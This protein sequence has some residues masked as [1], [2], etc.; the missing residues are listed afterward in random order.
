MAADEP[1]RAQRGPVFPRV[2]FGKLISPIEM[3]GSIENFRMTLEGS[4]RSV[5]GPTPY[6]PKYRSAGGAIPS[7]PGR[8][9]VY[10]YGPMHGIFHAV[11]QN[12]Q[13]EILLVHVAEELWTFEGWNKGWRVL[14]SATDSE[15]Q[16]SVR[17][18]DDVR[19]RA[20]TQFVAT[21]NGVIII[22]QAD[23][24]SRPYF[25]DGEVIL[26][27]GYSHAPSAPA[28]IGPTS[29]AGHENDRDSNTQGLS[30]RRHTMNRSRRSSAFF[31]GKFGTGRIGTISTIPDADRD[32]A[33]ERNYAIGCPYLLHGEWHGATQWIDYFGNLSPIS[34]D[35]QSVRLYRRPI[36][37]KTT[38]KTPY[39]GETLQHEFV[40]ASVESGPRGTIGRMLYRTKDT[41]N[42]GTSQ[43]FEVPSAAFG[44]SA[45]RSVELSVSAQFAT[46]PENGSRTFPDNVP[47]S[48]L[49]APARQIGPIPKFKI[50]EV[51]LGRLF[52]GN[53]P[54]DPGVLH[55]SIPGRWGTF[56]R[57]AILFPDPAG[58]A[59]TGLRR[60]EGGLLAFT[61]SSVYSIVP[62]DDGIGFR[63]FPLSTTV[64][65][66]APD[67]L[68]E[69]SN[70]LIVWLA[71]DGFYGFDGQQIVPLTDGLENEI[72]T[73]ARSRLIQA[74]ATV[75]PR[76]SEYLCW[77]P[78]GDSIYN[79][80]GYVFDGS[81][82][83][84]RTGAK[85]TALCTTADHRQYV[86]GCGRI[87]GD[88]GPDLDSRIEPQT[89]EPGQSTVDP[90]NPDTSGVVVPSDEDEAYWGVWVLDH[91][92][93]NFYPKSSN[94][95]PIFETAWIGAGEPTRK[96]ALTIKVWFRETSTTEQL[97]VRVYRDW[98][99]DDEVH[100][101]LI[102]LDSPDDPS[103]GWGVATPDDN[104]EWQKRRPYWVRKDIYVPSCEVFKLRFEGIPQTESVS[105]RVSQDHVVSA[106]I[107]IIG[108]VVDESPRA[109]GGR[110]PRSGS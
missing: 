20:P 92:T 65:C 36:G 51:A 34:Q 101:V 17:L 80:R 8:K 11:L 48:A 81:G 54:A 67:S 103:P 86:L 107:E 28:I 108:L 71:Y 52:A 13:R 12:G 3:A 100:S 68:A 110:M 26:P 38:D 44:R 37:W 73:F 91:E 31:H 49:I 82:W 77:L 93:R 47:D 74:T 18:T 41:L 16:I 88:Y 23:N 14:L 90:K 76:T 95:Q 102:D 35:S 15:A 98:R 27:L 89:L 24:D 10:D 64:G 29:P 42:S 83:K 56:E 4:L 43:L 60:V 21:P 104:A 62:S 72:K 99:K 61:Q 97:R 109:G 78:V 57:G 96:T 69:L 40:W 94:R 84:I 46:V 106:D 32:T 105:L 59:I 58:Q 50:A 53:T 9:D 30:I 55:Y 39:P 79:N 6:L 33:N 70:G 85:Y 66:V 5:R 1:L 25:Y 22:P 7:I 75:D 63:S 2:Q 87:N 45:D 19:P